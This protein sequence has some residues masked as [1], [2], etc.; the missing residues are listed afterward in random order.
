M[1]SRIKETIT[2]IVTGQLT[3]QE[4]AI[5]NGVSSQLREKKLHIGEFDPLNPH[6]DPEDRL[7]VEE[8]IEIPIR[9]ILSLRPLR[10][11]AVISEISK[12][13]IEYC[14]ENKIT[15]RY[16]SP[17]THSGKG[18]FNIILRELEKIEAL[19]NNLIDQVLSLSFT[20]EASVYGGVYLN[21]YIFWR[22]NSWRYNDFNYYE[23]M[24]LTAPGMLCTSEIILQVPLN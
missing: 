11:R 23:L 1:L 2:D 19:P 14:D 12:S 5:V 13:L 24:M 10:R 18:D 22:H 3:E 8:S 15:I 4:E 17:F 21:P 6:L 7:S 9:E 16:D 20:F